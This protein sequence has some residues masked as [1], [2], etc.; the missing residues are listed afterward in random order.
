MAVMGSPASSACMFW[1]G[2]A[3]LDKALSCLQLWR[4]VITGPTSNGLTGRLG[5]T[6]RSVMPWL[7]HALRMPYHHILPLCHSAA[8][9]LGPVPSPIVTQPIV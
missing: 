5:G 7:C 1:E 3:F 2:E 4:E 9:S 6:L 8:L